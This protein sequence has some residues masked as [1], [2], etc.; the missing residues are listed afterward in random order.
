VE[1][2]GRWFR[3][4]PD[5]TA[6]FGLIFVWVSASLLIATF[7]SWLVVGCV[8]AG[9]AIIAAIRELV[10]RRWDREV[11]QRPDESTSSNR[12]D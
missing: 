11:A 9:I 6:P 8:L 1:R 2:I 12:N 5:G 4:R 3:R 7:A 10:L